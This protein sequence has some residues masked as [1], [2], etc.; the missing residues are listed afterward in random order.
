MLKIETLLKLNYCIP[1]KSRQ[2]DSS[3]ILLD[4]QKAIYLPI[5]KVA[6]SSIKKAIADWQNIKVDI[7]SDAGIPLIHEAQFKYLDVAKFSRRKTYWKFCFVRNPWDRLV[8]CYKEKIKKDPNFHGKT[9]SFIDGVHKGLL[10]YGVFEA[11]M[12]FDAFVD[13]VVAIPDHDSDSHLR[14]QV[15]FIT[16]EGGDLLADFVG[17]FENLR[18][19]FA[20]VR[21]KL[22]AEDL[23]LTHINQ[24]KK[25]SYQEFY[26]DLTRE[27]V[28]KRY[29]NDI[30]TF[31]YKF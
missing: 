5:P 15:T 8:S 9:N 24:T 7:V 2:T 20:Y 18:A 13:A 25:S 6:C 4:K 23:Q 29:E 17:R 28:F 21:E 30:H 10:R 12:S 16:D 3:A 26:T 11:G 19:D 14:S 31:G 22:K 27:K 1:R